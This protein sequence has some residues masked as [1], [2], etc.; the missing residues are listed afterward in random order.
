MVR[1]NF[2]RDHKIEDEEIKRI[3]DRLRS[4]IIPDISVDYINEGLDGDRQ[5][6]EVMKIAYPIESVELAVSQG[7]GLKRHI[8][9]FKTKDMKQSVFATKSKKYI[10]GG[11]SQNEITITHILSFHDPSIRALGKGR[12]SL[13]SPAKEFLPV[14]SNTLEIMQNLRQG[15]I[16][17]LAEYIQAI[18]T[19]S[20]GHVNVNFIVLLWDIYQSNP[21]LYISRLIPAWTSVNKEMFDKNGKPISERGLKFT[22]PQ[23]ERS[24]IRVSLYPKEFLEGKSQVRN[25]DLPKVNIGFD[26]NHF[27]EERIQNIEDELNLRKILRKSN[28]AK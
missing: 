6:D 24:G 11:G 1:D 18:D 26:S 10:S 25:V 8:G 9:R 5:A 12:G 28:V 23:A 22:K 27:D 15:N 21:R 2:F 13:L 16:H 19:I 17:W 3:Q 14:G 7:L 20:D 4:V